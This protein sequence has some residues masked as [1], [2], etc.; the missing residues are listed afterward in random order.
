[1]PGKRIL[2]LQYIIF[3]TFIP[4]PVTLIC[5]AYLKNKPIYSAIEKHFTNKS[6][7]GIR[8]Y[9]SQNKV[10][11]MQMPNAL[12]EKSDMEEVFYSSAARVLSANAI[13]TA[14]GIP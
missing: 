8:V 4:A 9:E 5:K 13:P 1:M 11:L 2:P 10:A 12:G 7:T 3:L 14:I 6:H